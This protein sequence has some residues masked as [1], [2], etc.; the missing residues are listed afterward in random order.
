[1]GIRHS[2]LPGPSHQPRPRKKVEARH[3]VAVGLLYAVHLSECDER[4]PRAE[5][6]VTLACFR[7]L[8]GVGYTL[9]RTWPA[10]LLLELRANAG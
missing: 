10:V 2:V 8:R 5:P 1:M 7:C 9:T 6:D 3:T 4:A